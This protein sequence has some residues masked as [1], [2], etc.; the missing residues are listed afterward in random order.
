M[1]DDEVC[2]TVPLIQ[3]KKTGSKAPTVVLGN[4]LQIKLVETETIP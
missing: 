3:D 1:V 4:E 2:I